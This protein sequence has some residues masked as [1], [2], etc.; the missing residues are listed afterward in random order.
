ML[1]PVEIARF[2]RTEPARLCCSDPHLAAG[3]RY[4][5]RCPAE[6]GLSSCKTILPAISCPAAAPGIVPQRPVGLPVLHT[7]AASLTYI[8]VNRRIFYARLWAGL[9]FDWY[10][11]GLKNNNNAAPSWPTLSIQNFAKSG[12][13][14]YFRCGCLV[15][16]GPRFACSR[17]LLV[18]CR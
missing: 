11:C 18:C 5:L 4:L 10:I 3:R 7:P 17:G 2:T 9:C 13:S 16:C 8:P 14:P 12:F 1:L 15:R 6:S